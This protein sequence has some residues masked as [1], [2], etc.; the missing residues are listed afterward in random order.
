MILEAEAYDNEDGRLDSSKVVWRSSID[1]AIA[2]GRSA[3]V[4]V[5]PMPP[6]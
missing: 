5:T 6:P 3:T 4:T 1:G 2:T